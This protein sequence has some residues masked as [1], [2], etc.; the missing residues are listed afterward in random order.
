MGEAQLSRASSGGGKCL[1]ENMSLSEYNALLE[2]KVILAMA[3]SGGRIE[4]FTANGTFTA[5]ATR[6]YTVYVVGG[7]GGGGGEGGM[8]SWAGTWTA[9]GGGGGS[10]YSNTIQIKLNKNQQV[11]YT[12][13]VGGS[14]GAR[15]VN[16]SSGY[17]CLSAGGTGGTG[18]TSSFG[19]YISAPGGSGGI[20]GSRT[21]SDAYYPHPGSGGQGQN[22][23][24]VGG[25]PYWNGSTI[26]CTYGNGAG[27]MGSGANEG[28]SGSYGHGGSSG[29]N[30]FNGVIVVSWS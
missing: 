26:N 2:D 1:F 17:G 11:S 12:V 8:S 7:G 30:G 4:V 20:G 3:E 16:R 29:A 9:P 10:G 18:G 22:V 15:N 23:G 25:V 21:A 19:S 13:G 14:A 28:T 27:G 24:A 6:Y 5:N